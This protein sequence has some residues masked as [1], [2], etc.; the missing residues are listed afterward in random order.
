[1]FNINAPSEWTS[2]ISELDYFNGD[3]LYLRAEYIDQ[4]YTVPNDDSHSVYI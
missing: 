1:M 2:S 4:F 3:E